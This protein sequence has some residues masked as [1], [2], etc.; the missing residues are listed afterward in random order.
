MNTRHAKKLVS[1]F[2]VGIIAA[3]AG[4]LGWHLG[5]KN[6]QKAAA[7][8]REA[9]MRQ[10][11][12]GRSLLYGRM[13]ESWTKCLSMLSA[14]VVFLGD[15][16]TAGG[17]WQT[18]FPYLDTV[19]LGLVGDTL[20]GISQRVGQVRAVM[21]EKC[22]L[23]IG[24][25]NLIYGRTC[26]EI[27]TDHDAV[28]TALDA[29]ET[30]VYVQSVL[31]VIEAERSESVANAQIRELN[32]GLQALAQA[33]ALPYVDLYPL[34]ADADGSLRAAYSS[35]GLH[36]SELGYEVWQQALAPYVDE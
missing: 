11:S 22:F 29:E 16:I 25:N 23:L 20:E 17:D 5:S 24:V 9:Y 27:L 6:A 14:N 3:A 4:C 33:H 36:L 13:A 8:A 18:Y 2:L 1:I 10:Y 31:P 26:A 19:N 7:Q 30:M 32:E 28:L 15:S 35:D 12:V 34:F 21:P